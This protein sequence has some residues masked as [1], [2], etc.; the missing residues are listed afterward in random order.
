MHYDK[1]RIEYKTKGV[2]VSHLKQVDE[3]LFLLPYGTL[4]LPFENISFFHLLLHSGICQ[5]PL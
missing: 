2:C 3:N 1:T 5:L 4:R